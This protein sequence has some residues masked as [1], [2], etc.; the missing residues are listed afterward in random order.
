MPGARHH[1]REFW[2]Q[3]DG[4]AVDLDLQEVNVGHDTSRRGGYHLPH[5]SDRSYHSIEY[6]ENEGFGDK[7]WKIIWSRSQITMYIV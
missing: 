5:G 2:V 6:R 3:T 4:S 1:A 7:L